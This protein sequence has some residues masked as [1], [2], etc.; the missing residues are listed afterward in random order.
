MSADQMF[1][2]ATR[3][4][5]DRIPRRTFIGRI[6]L[7]MTAVG[8]GGLGFASAAPAVTKTCGAGCTK[9]DGDSTTC[10]GT[11]CHGCPSGTCAGGSWYMCSPTICAPNFLVRYRDCIK[12]AS[13]CNAYCGSD[14]RP[15]CHFDTPYGS[16]GGHTRVYCRS[17][18]CLGPGSCT[19]SIFCNPCCS[20]TI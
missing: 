18:T 6:A 15:G 8:A 19:G 17:I 11:T 1:E 4:F 2:R 16:C 12:A 14:H 9:C 3:L 20:I 10:G 13:N 5:G 7:G